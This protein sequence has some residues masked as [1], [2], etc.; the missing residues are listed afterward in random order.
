MTQAFEA[1]PLKGTDKNNRE[2]R[3]T[4]KELCNAASV[5]ERT[6]RYYIQQ[7][8]LPPPEGAG[9]SSHYNR[10]HLS[11][12]ALVRR[13]KAALLPLSEIKQLMSGVPSSQLEEVAHEFYDELTRTNPIAADMNLLRP[14][15][16]AANVEAVEETKKALSDL[17]IFVPPE[18]EL[19]PEETGV[20]GVSENLAVATL[21]K[22]QR[23]TLV[24]GLELHYEE[25]G[26]QD[27]EQGQAKLALLLDFANQLFANR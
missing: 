13:L 19:P 16:R 17:E 11:R 24:A 22:W 15:S 2:V 7:G 12:L 3:L 6:V 26:P 18:A 10:E 1:T 14:V 25:G 23:L 4:L 9:P 21:G 5:T 27:N 8:I 20:T